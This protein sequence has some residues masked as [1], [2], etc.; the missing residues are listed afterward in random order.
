MSLNKA[1]NAVIALVEN[2]TDIA[3]EIFREPGSDIKNIP[4]ITA[5]LDRAVEKA[6]A[7]AMRNALKRSLAVQLQEP[8]LKHFMKMA[9]TDTQ[10]AVESAFYEGVD[11]IERLFEGIVLEMDPQ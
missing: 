8:R 1:V 11:A 9:G 4:A 2:R 7:T 5:R 6:A 10:G 3:K